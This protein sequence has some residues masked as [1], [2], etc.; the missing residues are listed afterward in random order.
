MKILK[1][2]LLLLSITSISFAQGFRQ[3]QTDSYTRYELLNPSNQSF[4]I[5]YDVSATTAG[6]TKYFNGLRVGSEHLVDAV[7]D[8]MTG[9][10]LNW[11]IVNGVKA[12]GN[13]LSNA[14]EAGEYLMVDLARPVPEGGQARIRIDKTYKDVNSYYQE[15]GTIVFD[16][17]LGIKRNSV[18]LPLGY[19]LVGANYPSQV[20]QEEDG[21]IKVSFM[22]EGPAG[23]PYKVTARLAFNMKYVAPSKTNPWTEYQS[24][25]QGRDK[26]KARTGMNVSERGFQDRDIVYFLQQPESNS[27]FLYHDYTESRVGMDKYVNI[28]RAGSKASKPSAIILD[29]GEAL[30]V[31]TLVGQAIVAK[32]IEANG[33]TDETEAVVI[34]YDPIKK[35][36]T[37]RLRIS[38]TYT[39]A[40]RYL[41]HEGQLIWDRS[42]GRNRNTIVLPKGWMVTSSSIP[43][44]IDMTE[45]DEVRISFINGRPDNI[46]V[47][48][49]AVRR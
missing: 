35:G 20:T 26:T 3:T 47:F 15:D 23:V 22:N 25:P 30:K 38:E 34:W 5:I 13:G 43:G 28:V 1:L 32:G 4:R 16:R 27:F 12:K 24:S 11:E 36:E 48:V 49:R 14:N 46:D 2:S 33:L 44:R 17:S 37:R 18:V 41:L 10:E 6:A 42:F 21:R 45:D 19:E 29:T 40:S 31:E 9:K 8:L 7:W 39:D